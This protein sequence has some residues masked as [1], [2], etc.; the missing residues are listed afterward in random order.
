MKLSRCTAR[1]SRRRAAR[2]EIIRLMECKG[3][4]SRAITGASGTG[5]MSQGWNFV[6]T[7]AIKHAARRLHCTT[8]K[9]KPWR[10]TSQL[11]SC[12]SRRHYIN[13]TLSI[14]HSR[15]L[16]A[17]SPSHPPSTFSSPPTS[18]TCTT[19]RSTE[20]RASPSP[21]PI[22]AGQAPSLI[23]LYLV[24]IYFNTRHKPNVIATTTT[25]LV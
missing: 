19:Q 16:A 11:T 1:G 20:Q 25:T 6:T 4:A 13:L 10:R 23:P 5:A 22:T 15:P 2:V 7:Y 24:H 17:A 18:R 21:S 8:G 9:I 3:G 12:P 14:V